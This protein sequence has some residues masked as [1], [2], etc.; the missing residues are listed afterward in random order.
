L[1]HARFALALLALALILAPAAPVVAPSPTSG[2]RLVD[3]PAAGAHA[4]AT[5]AALANSVEAR[6]LS[7]RLLI[8]AIGVDASIE[9]VG[10]DGAGSMA[11]PSSPQ[12]VG[13]YQ[14]GPRPG[15][16]GDAVIDG[17]LDWT[18]G[19]AVFWQLHR[20]VAGDSI[21]VAPLGGSPISFHVTSV[22]TYSAIERPPAGLFAAS[23]S[24]RL[25]LITCA[26][27]WDATR[28]M[29][30]LRLVVDAVLD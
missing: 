2:L 1:S 28:G 26:G 17:H 19:P 21:V 10:L 12:R 24:P 15:A 3:R 30:A 6:T 18:S 16:A 7:D 20:L 5:P 4:D 25:S 29:Y 9:P 8:A 11:A 22:R 14:F 13:W 27:A 23:G